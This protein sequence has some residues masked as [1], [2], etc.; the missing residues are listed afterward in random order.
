M[1]FGGG[2]VFLSVDAFTC[3]S[4]GTCFA[5]VSESQ[6]E[7]DSPSHL[8][9]LCQGLGGFF[10]LVFCFCSKCFCIS[11]VMCH[12]R[13][14]A[15]FEAFRKKVIMGIRHLN[16]HG[17]LPPSSGVSI[18]FFSHFSVSTLTAIGGVFPPFRIS[19]FPHPP[20]PAA[21]IEVATSTLDP[22][23]SHSVGS[24]MKLFRLS[25]FLLISWKFL[26]RPSATLPTQN[27]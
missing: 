14:N 10:S 24:V 5:I 22:Q 15:W 2:C 25:L 12:V 27:S 11:Q 26:Q 23:H 19:R 18:H 16:V 6:S 1:F 21:I 20:S 13:E 9:S 17:S 4:Q 8:V 7:S 3:S